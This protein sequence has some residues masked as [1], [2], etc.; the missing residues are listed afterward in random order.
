MR[1]NTVLLLLIM[2]LLTPTLNAQQSEENNKSEKTKNN[3][4]TALIIESQVKGSQEQPKVIYILPWQGVSKPITINKQQNKTV[5]PSFEPINPKEFRMQVS[6][7]H[8][9]H[10]KTSVPVNK[11]SSKQ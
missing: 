8:R 10:S 4:S 6:A 11:P 2:W 1:I 5:L 3:K 9:E 7:F